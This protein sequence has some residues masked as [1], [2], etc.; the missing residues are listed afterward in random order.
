MSARSLAMGVV[1]MIAVALPFTAK[2]LLV[3]PI[4]VEMLSIGTGASAAIEVVNDR[5]TPVTVEVTTEKLNVPERGAVT[6]EPD[7]GADFLIF[8]PQAVV[9]AGGRQVFRVRWVGDPE[10]DKTKLYMFSTSELPVGLP[11]GTTGVEIY[12]AVQSIVSVSP[13]NAR[14]DISVPTI[15]RYTDEAGGT[16]VLV[17]F[18]NDGNAHAY[19]GTG[20]LELT[21]I[22][23]WSQTL[24]PDAVGAALGLGLIPPSASR[25]MFIPVEGVPADGTIS[26]TFTAQSPR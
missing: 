6:T 20:Q 4:V 2:A 22:G 12:Y 11:G 10:F 17:T 8:P 13:P 25:T 14:P 7:D 15:D 23:G 3:Q 5:N 24:T 18:R 9:P 19:V 16:G 1:G 26:A 21:T